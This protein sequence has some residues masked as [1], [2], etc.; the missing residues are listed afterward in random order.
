MLDSD[1]VEK[2]WG[3]ELAVMPAEVKADA[4][5]I[6]YLAVMD[7]FPCPDQVPQ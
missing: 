3:E 7:K 6:L 2:L 5:L 1:I 4:A